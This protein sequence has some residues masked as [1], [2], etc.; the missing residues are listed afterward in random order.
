[1]GVAPPQKYSHSVLGPVHL[2]APAFNAFWQCTCKEVLLI[3]F[4]HL[5]PA[6][7]KNYNARVSNAAK[8]R[9]CSGKKNFLQIRLSYVWGQRSSIPHMHSFYFVFLTLSLLGVMK[10]REPLIAMAFNLLQTVRFSYFFILLILYLPL[11]P[12]KHMSKE[13]MPGNLRE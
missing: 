4:L 10:S 1:M 8:A 3:S 9:A 5:V 12:L 7:S 13:S 11:S 6:P 2:P